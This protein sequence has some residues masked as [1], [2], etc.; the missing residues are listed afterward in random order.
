MTSTYKIL[1]SHNRPK[2]L[3]RVLSEYKSFNSIQQK[4]S[5]I[6]CINPDKLKLF[7][8]DSSPKFDTTAEALCNSIAASYIHLP[9]GTF[10]EK[11]I[12]AGELVEKDCNSIN[13]WVDLC[14]DQDIFIR[15]AP[16]FNFSGNPSFS[17]DIGLCTSLAWGLAED[18]N[19]IVLR[20]ATFRYGSNGFELGNLLNR[21]VPLLCRIAY[22][23]SFWTFSSTRFFIKRCKLIAA[24]SKLIP[25]HDSKLIEIFLNIFHSF[26]VYDFFDESIVLRSADVR[27]SLRST[28]AD[29]SF[30]KKSFLQSYL[31]IRSN[32]PMIY[33]SM[34]EALF[35]SIKDL[36]FSRWGK[37]LEIERSQLIKLFEL[38]IASYGSLLAYDFM[39]RVFHLMP[40]TADATLGKIYAMRFLPASRFVYQYNQAVPLCIHT[41][42]D[43]TIFKIFDS[44]SPF[45][46]KFS[47]DIINHINP[48]YWTE[49][50]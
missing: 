3:F 11:L 42:I 44:S 26:A 1:L 36:V 17:P 47:C 43:H 28:Q 2:Q 46:D 50:S 41:P 13:S 20:D 10:L 14:T 34:F 4:Q 30:L 16:D 5:S 27:S 40:S 48:L 33:N 39:Q 22:P 49:C 24:L 6:T 45:A 18:G 21:Q 38:N 35:H 31:D 7:I 32:S 12:F 37:S 9:T 25:H 23:D 15:K 8:L 29:Q 19:S